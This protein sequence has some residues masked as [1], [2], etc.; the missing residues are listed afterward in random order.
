MRFHSFNNSELESRT[1]LDLLLVRLEL[2]LR[3]LACEFVFN[4]K[5][6][7]SSALCPCFFCPSE[8]RVEWEYMKIR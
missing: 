7:D 4:D 8:M 6:I 1:L 3:L 2:V 5:W